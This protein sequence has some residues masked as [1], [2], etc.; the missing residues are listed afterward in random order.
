[1]FKT[2]AVR[3]LVWF[4]ALAPVTS[5]AFA[6]DRSADEEKLW[7]LEQ[8]YWRLV[9]ANDLDHYRQLWHAQFLG[10]PYVSPEPLG[11]AHITDWI[12]VHTAKGES[13]KSYQLERLQMQ[14]VDDVATTTYR[15]RMIWVDKKGG[16]QAATIRVIHTWLRNP[17]GTWKI[18]S[19]MSAPTN[20]EGH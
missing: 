11:K 2:W 14:I 16:E 20:A 13:L 6:V 18:V 1:M 4:A 9:Q 3:V 15:M 19:G 10:W 8:T 5:L 12:T 17:D 7:S